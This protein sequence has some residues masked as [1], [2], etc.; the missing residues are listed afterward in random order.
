MNCKSRKSR[1]CFLLHV[2][3]VKGWKEV[4]RTS[5]CIGIVWPRT[6]QRL[7]Q[8]SHVSS[9]QLSHTPKC[10]KCV[11]GW[12]TCKKIVVVN[13]L[14]ICQFCKKKQKTPPR[15]SPALP[16][17]SNH[18]TGKARDKAKHSG[19]QLRPLTVHHS[20]ASN[21]T[22]LMCTNHSFLLKGKWSSIVLNFTKVVQAD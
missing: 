8:L 18:F 2:R 1:V 22:A 9:V 14:A 7:C 3:N 4:E 21:Q 16:Y 15:P 5:L 6:E 10:W 11:V 20:H 12:T 19:R 17:S 13:N